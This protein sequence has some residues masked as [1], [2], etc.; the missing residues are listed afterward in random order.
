MDVM[1]IVVSD[2]E[3]SLMFRHQNKDDIYCIGS[4]EADKYFFVNE[5]ASRLYMHVIALM[6]GQHTLDEIKNMQSSDEVIPLEA[7]DKIYHTCLKCNLI[8][9]DNCQ[10]KK[11]FNEKEIIFRDILKINIVPFRNWCRKI[12]T[13]AYV[14]MIVLMFC[15]IVTSF[16]SMGE[17]FR[18]IPWE[19]VVGDV[20]TLFYAVMISS[21]SLILHEMAHAVAGSKMGLPIKTAHLAVFAYTTFACYVKLAGIY[22]LKPG[23]RILIWVAGSFMN[24]FL[25]STATLLFGLFGEQGQLFLSVVIV[26]NIS[27]IV[28][29]VVPFY[30]SD[31]YFILST[32]CKA[33]NL[34]KNIFKNLKEFFLERKI[35]FVS[36]AYIIYF[37]GTIVFT[38]FSIVLVLFP[39][40][41]N[42]AIGVGEGG[43]LT[44]IISDNINIVIVLGVLV[45]SGTIKVYK[46]KKC[47]GKDK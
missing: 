17:V 30:I 7:I 21:V 5:R 20:R 33:P 34:R 46:K 13:K 10:E 35:H 6:D 4:S 15:I 3:C 45:I 29:A 36:F 2:I 32:I 9:N 19:N 14:V 44:Q 26:S 25:I 12:D 24:L 40:I 11:E 23:K 22:F 47:P 31:G 42:I 39:M 38:G 1:P 18:M 37:L 27:I 41:H 8:V 28:S 43:A 16:F